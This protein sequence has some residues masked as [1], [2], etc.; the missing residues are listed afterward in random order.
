[1]K[2]KLLIILRNVL[3]G[4][5]VLYGVCAVMVEIPPVQR[6]FTS[7]AQEQL[8]R[9]IGTEVKIGHITIGYPNRFIVDDLIVNDKSGEEMLKAARF[10]AKME[11]MPLLTEGRLSMHTMQM[12]GFH[13]HLK[14]KTPKDEPNTSSSSMPSPQPTPP[15][16]PPP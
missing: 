16:R 11:W 6:W 2:R 13:A 8:S 1:M 10:S 5:I 12:F 3:I 4:L 7:V 9:F 14:R 15:N